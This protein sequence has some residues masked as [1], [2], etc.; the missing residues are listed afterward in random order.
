MMKISGYL[1]IASAIAFA[2]AA[3]IGNILSLFAVSAAF[4]ALGIT[5]IRK[6]PH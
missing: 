6:A 4:I 5:Q 1:F 2:G 3:L